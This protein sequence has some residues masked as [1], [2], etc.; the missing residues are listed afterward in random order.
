MRKLGLKLVAG[1]VVLAGAYASYHF[2]RP[3]FWQTDTPLRATSGPVDLLADLNP[4]D[5]DN[6]W[7]ERKFFRITPADYRFADHDGSRALRCSTDNSASIL[8][9]DTDIAVADLPILSWRWKVVTPI[10]SDLDEATREGDD[11]PMRFY[12]RFANETGDSKGVEIIWS[13]QKFEPGGFKIIGDFYHL[14]ANGRDENVGTWHD[15]RVDL[16]QLYTD[17]GGTG[18]PKLD[19]IGF[20]CDS[21]NTGARSDGYFADVQL[22]EG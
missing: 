14:V 7:K 2:T 4:Q 13:N 21:D 12:I 11:H 6:G 3:P 1:V 20:F 9:L 22:L 10:Q 18:T 15:Q 19:V 17:I 8:A 5:P 16:A